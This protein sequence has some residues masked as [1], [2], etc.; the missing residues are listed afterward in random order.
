MKRELLKFKRIYN[1]I[2]HVVT[3]RTT[4]R[5]P[6]TSEP[7]LG[8]LEREVGWGSLIKI[9][10]SPASKATSG[11]FIIVVLYLNTIM[12]RPRRWGYVL[13]ELHPGELRLQSA[14]TAKTSQQ[15]P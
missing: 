10:A 12:E 3:S 5:S 2:L 1:Y 4:P 8:D 9:T 7:G 11:T 6:Q 15:V 14:M 13:Y